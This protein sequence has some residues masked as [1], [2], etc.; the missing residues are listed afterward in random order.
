MKNCEYS[1]SQIL[2]ARI[3]TMERALVALFE[4]VHRKETDDVAKHFDV[5]KQEAL[6]Q[7]GVSKQHKLEAHIMLDFLRQIRNRVSHDRPPPKDPRPQ[8]HVVK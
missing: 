2:H 7:R 1:E 5:L 6:G 4:V 3:S 8:L